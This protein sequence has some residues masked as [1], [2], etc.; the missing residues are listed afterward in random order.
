MGASSST[1]RATRMRRPQP[2]VA[3]QRLREP[4]RAGRCWPAQRGATAPARRPA[5]SAAGI[6]GG[7]RVGDG[8]G[9]PADRLDR[10]P[11]GRARRPGWRSGGCGSGPGGWCP[12][13]AGMGQAVGGLMQQGAQH[14]DRAALEAFA[15]DQDLVRRSAGRGPASG[16]GRSDPDSAACLRSLPEATTS[17]ASGTSGWRLRMAGQVCSRAATKRL[18]AARSAGGSGGH[19]VPGPRRSDRGGAAAVL[20]ERP[21]VGFGTG[22]PARGRSWR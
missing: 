10:S 16:G 1:E 7:G 11:P 4:A 6:G 20:L 3:G 12:D 15:A 17:T 14:V 8:G 5:R 19:G 9:G 18:A 21:G 22:R 13:L 2:Q